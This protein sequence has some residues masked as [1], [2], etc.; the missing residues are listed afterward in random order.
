MLTNAQITELLKNN[1]ISYSTEESI[2]QL[3][4]EGKKE[5]ILGCRYL[6]LV[7]FI[8]LGQLA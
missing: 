1:I 2:K 6:V 7:L 8:F 3:A 5:A 4:D